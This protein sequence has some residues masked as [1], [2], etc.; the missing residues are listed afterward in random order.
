MQKPIKKEQ[1]EVWKELDYFIMFKKSSKNQFQ[2]PLVF[3]QE[4]IGSGEP[5]MGT[6]SATDGAW[7]QHVLLSFF[8][9]EGE[10]TRLAPE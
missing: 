9:W 5:L 4:K 6:H 10:W 2:L 1:C 7:K 3:L 8:D